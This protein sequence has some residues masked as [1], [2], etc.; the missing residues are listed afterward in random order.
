VLKGLDFCVLI[1]DDDVML[2]LI[3]ERTLREAQMF[4]DRSK[5]QIDH[6]QPVYIFFPVLSPH[7]ID[8]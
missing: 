8:R 3:I 5:L 2:H 7:Y 6:M 1:L 4:L